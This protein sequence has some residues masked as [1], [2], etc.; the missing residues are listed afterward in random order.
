MSSSSVRAVSITMK[1]SENSRRSLQTSRPSNIGEVQVQGDQIRLGAA[2][3]FHPGQAGLGLCDLEALLDQDP[4][5][6]A[7]DIGVVL[8][9]N[10]TADFGHGWHDSTSTV[11]RLPGHVT[12]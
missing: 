9:H 6:E 5:Q 2:D 11:L 1:A 3:L 7:A 12:G 8:D 4:D 10:G